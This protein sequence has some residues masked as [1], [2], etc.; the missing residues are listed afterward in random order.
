[1]RTASVLTAIVALCFFGGV[2][3]QTTPRAERGVIIFCLA[4]TVP[5][6][7]LMFHGVRLPF[8]RWLESAVGKGD[9][10]RWVRTVY[11]PLTEE[12]AKLWPLLLPFVRRAITPASAGRFALAL[13]LG[14][15]L[16]EIFT[17]AGLV[18]AKSPAIAALPWYLLGGFIIER[19]MTCGIHP[20]MTAVAL[21]VWQRGGIAS[22]GSPE[23]GVPVAERGMTG[24]EIQSNTSERMHGKRAPGG[25]RFAA[26][27]ALAMLAHYLANFP[28]T[29]AQRGWLG[30][31]VT[32]AQTLVF[33]WVLF[34]FFLACAW[35]TRL[36]FPHTQ[37]GR[38]FHGEA[39]CPE[40][41]RRYA[42]DLLLGLNAGPRR[43]YERCPHCKKWH[44]TKRLRKNRAG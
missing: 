1:M 33:L 36:L 31:N 22:S 43:R 39:V 14:F 37:L 10:L 42:R 27:L 5:M 41:G 6:C 17:V 12:P 29:M 35:L 11:A 13:G 7:W 30:G 40:C 18:A 34:C 25:G 38:Q 32:L 9:A 24:G 23:G 44:W 19:M 21:A 4:A 28:I 16:G 26:G 20:G 15:G 2:L 3:W 8:D